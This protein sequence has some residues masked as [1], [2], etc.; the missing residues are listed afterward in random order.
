MVEA[1]DIIMTQKTDLS[2]VAVDTIIMAGEDATII[3]KD[4]EKQ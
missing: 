2:M 3:A 4:K 1:V